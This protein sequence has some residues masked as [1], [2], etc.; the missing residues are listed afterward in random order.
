MDR[1]CHGAVCRHRAL[2]HYFG[3]EY[4]AESCGACDLCL[5]ETALV[6]DANTVA[7]KI[8]S[9]VARVKERFGI[10]HVSG[11]LRGESSENIVKWGHDKLSTF[12]LLRECS[13]RDLRAWMYQLIGQQ[14]LVQAGDEYPVLHLNAASWEVMRGQRSVRLVQPVRRKKKEKTRAEVVSWEG[15]DQS[16]FEALRRL[17][18]QV[19][20]ERQVPPYIVFTDA[21]LRQLA[22]V[23]PTTPERM[24]QVSGVGDAKLR[25][26]GERFLEVIRQH[27]GAPASPPAPAADA[28]GRAF[29]L[30]RRGTALGEVGRDL[31]QPHAV[32]VGYLCEYIH[33]ER[34]RSLAPWV[35]DQTYQRVAAAV[36]QFGSEQ[37][38]PLFLALG[39]RVTHEEIRL[40]LAHLRPS[41]RV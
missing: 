27:V 38:Q 24:R 31:G 40:V 2:V 34:P 10:N 17:R 19:A 36:R 4:R 33:S 7:Q 5:A 18:R 16:L 39:R 22:A 6:A 3:Q 15:V 37:L 32:V 12:G 14:V 23:R 41:P 13:K 11:V 35:A 29:D 21:T 28:R 20:E 25:D 9:C 30:F 1:Y 8:L 26:L